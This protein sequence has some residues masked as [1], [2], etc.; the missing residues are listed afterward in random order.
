M[1]DSDVRNPGPAHE[2]PNQKLLIYK[3]I[4]VNSGGNPSSRLPPKLVR[5]E[6]IGGRL[7]RRINKH[8]P[9]NR[10]AKRTAFILRLNTRV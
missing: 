10:I 4:D 8:N 1:S 2:F 6:F 5:F 3:G 7:Q 9:V